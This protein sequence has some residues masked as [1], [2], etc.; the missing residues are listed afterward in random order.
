MASGSNKSICVIC[1]IDSTGWIR[2]DPDTK[3]GPDWGC[4]SS[5]ISWKRTKNRSTFDLRRDWG[6]RLDLR[7]PKRR[8]QGSVLCNSDES[9]SQ[10][11]QGVERLDVTWSTQM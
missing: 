3:G 8:P 2:V 7:W 1:L 5:S 9:G 4:P 11:A 6:L 10:W